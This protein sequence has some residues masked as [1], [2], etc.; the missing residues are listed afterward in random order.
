MTKNEL[1]EK[2]MKDPPTHIGS[3]Y[4]FLSNLMKDE[5][6]KISEKWQIKL[7]ITDNSFQQAFLVA[8]DVLMSVTLQVQFYKTCFFLYYNQTKLQS[9]EKGRGPDACAAPYI[10][11]I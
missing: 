8:Q 2:L 7:D 1:I 3:V 6:A 11:L 10:R 5:L 4:L 9:G